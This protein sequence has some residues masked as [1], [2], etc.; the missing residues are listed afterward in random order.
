MPRVGAV[1]ARLAPPAP[2]RGSGHDHGSVDVD[3]S[4]KG[5]DVFD[6]TA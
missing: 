2:R 4:G 3:E 1:D 6:I 5:L